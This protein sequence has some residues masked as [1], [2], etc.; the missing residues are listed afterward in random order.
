MSAIQPAM[1]WRCMIALAITIL[2]ASCTKPHII[3]SAVDFNKA[4]ATFAQKEILLN[5][6]RAS[7]KRSLQYSAIS[8]GN[9]ALTREA[10]ARGSFSFL[11]G[12]NI[13]LT[14]TGFSLTPTVWA[15]K[16]DT[17]N[18][19]NLNSA[20]FVGKM[21]EDVTPA[22]YR[23]ATGRDIE[24]E[25]INLLFLRDITLPK[26][27]Y[28]GIV[29]AKDERCAK[30]KRAGSDQPDLQRDFDL[31]KF[32]EGD[33]ETLEGLLIEARR[34]HDKVR[35]RICSK[36][37]PDIIKRQRRKSLWFPNLAR[38]E[39][40]FV[41]FRL[42]FRMLRLLDME[43]KSGDETISATPTE[44]EEIVHG[45]DP[46]DTGNLVYKQAARKLTIKKDIKIK[47]P[48]ILELT[49]TEIK[50]NESRKLA[51][52]SASNSKISL[53]SPQEMI[54]YLGDLIAAQTHPDPHLRYTPMIVHGIGHT[55]AVLFRVQKGKASNAAVRVVDDDGEEYSV[56]RPVFGT[57]E[58]D[59]S[60]R[61]LSVINLTI[62]LRTRRKDLPVS[63]TIS[64]TQ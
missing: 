3:K 23:L 43:F 4:M 45:Y 11:D 53:R 7:K 33:I 41:G 39:C 55:P 20:E 1:L 61:V 47:R 48:L 51:V 29:N 40:D 59:R 28:V 54:R 30:A 10:N 35:E 52:A 56:P 16:G 8:G 44:S 9:S 13:P 42:V 58:E 49:A 5:A 32:I 60:L 37:I 12:R 63:S 22:N 25:L 15:R 64:V 24:E 46:R 17:S 57:E 18:I 27:S 38:Y 21:I 34:D 62:A 26:A 2:L 50:D 6:V 19:S 14:F 31:C 36:K